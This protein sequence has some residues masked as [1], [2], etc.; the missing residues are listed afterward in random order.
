MAFAAVNGGDGVALVKALPQLCW[1]L[2]LSN[3]LW[4]TIYD[5]EYAMVDRDEDIEAGAKSTAILFGDADRPILAVL[6]ATFLFSMLLVGT[7]AKLG[8]PY[9]AGLG[10]AAALLGWQQWLMRERTRELCFA[11]FRH[12]NW[13]GAVLWLGIFLALALR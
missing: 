4:S 12:N 1:L 2:F 3:V 13:V 5:T 9:F 7:R 6:M 11:A 8:W 10:G